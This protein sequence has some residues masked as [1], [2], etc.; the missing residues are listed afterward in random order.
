MAKS[1]AIIIKR[2]RKAAHGHHGGAWKVAYADFVTA[3]MAFFLLLWLLNATTDAQKRGIADY[4]SPTLATKAL[5]SGAGGVLG[6]RTMTETGSQANSTAPPSV[7]VELNKPPDV[8]DE[9]NAD[10]PGKVP[11]QDDHPANGAGNPNAQKPSP[12]PNDQANDI[13]SNKLSAEDRRDLAQMG[14]SQENLDKLSDEQFRKLEAAREEREFK[15]AEA[16]L[17]QA[18]QSEPGLQALAQNLVV[19]RT[20]EGLRIQL[21]DQDKT[22]MFPSGSAEPDEA[23]RKL[24]R[25]VAKVVDKMPNKIAITGHTDATPYRGTEFDNYD[26]SV[27]R[28]RSMRHALIGLGTPGERIATVQGK[29]A[30]EPLVKDNPTSAINRRVSFVLLREFPGGGAAPAGA[31][32]APGAPPGPAAPAPAPAGTAPAAAPPAP[33][34]PAGPPPLRTQPPAAPVPV[35]PSPAGAPPR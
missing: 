23:A 33:T 17:H 4:F 22:A 19:E 29:G 6:G 8:E 15:Q 20:S 12:N 16:E 13:M 10:T 11:S 35:S 24:M 21:V 7:A 18:I 5:T 25:L 32:P 9:D 28:A 31:A 2:V 26:L 27:E 34:Q 14:V 1:N 30:T 3:M